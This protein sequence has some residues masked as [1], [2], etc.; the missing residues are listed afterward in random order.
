MNRYRA[1]FPLDEAPAP[2]GDGSF[3]GVNALGNPATLEPGIVEHALNMRFEDGM[4]ST[5]GGIRIMPWGCVGGVTPYGNVLVGERFQDPIT[6]REWIVSVTES[7]S[8]KARAGSTASSIPVGSGVSLDGAVDLVQTYNGMVALRGRKAAVWMENVVEGWKA[9][10]SP[11]T[12]R[13]AMPPATFG[14]YY[15]NRLFLVDARTSPRYVDSVWVSDFGGVTSVLQ[16]SSA[17]QSFK[18]N[19]GTADRLNSLHPLGKGTILCGKSSSI[20]AVSGVTGT[21]EQLALNA[22]LDVVTTEYGC[23]SPRSWV[24]VGADAWFLAH[25]R[26]VASIRQTEQNALLGVDVPVS[27]RIQRIIDRINWEAADRVVAANSNNRVYFAVPLD[28]SIDNNAILVYSL[29]TGEWA[30]YDK[31]D[32]TLVRDFVVFPYGGSNRLGFLSQNGYVCLLDDGAYDHIGDSLGN[33]TYHEIRTELRTRGYAGSVKGR[34]KFSRVEWSIQGWRPSFSVTAVRE[35]VNERT[36]IAERA[37]DRTKYDVP[38]GTPDWNPTNANG[39]WAV[40]GR[41]DYSLNIHTAGGLKLDDGLGAGTSAHDVFQTHDDGCVI[42][43][44]SRSLQV[45]IVNTQGMIKITGV[46]VD[47]ERGETSDGRKV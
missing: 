20:W 11:D 15:Q 36:L 23:R 34:K 4:P 3:R 37:P 26:G 38:A 8:Y 22:E 12:G 9:L 6:G 43:E 41:Q 5:R 13:E 1:Y 19:Q 44:Q 42:L 47:S 27:R 32:A 10:P 33:L 7:S 24:S 39:D 21:N 29:L 18:I 28:G 25:E 31:S 14:L 2:D 40:S 16:G 35:G 30:G 45:E 17:Y 46:S